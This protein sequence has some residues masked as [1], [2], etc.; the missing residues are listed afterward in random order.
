MAGDILTLPDLAN[1]LELLRDSHCQSLYEGELA[2][3]IIDWSVKTG[4]LL[5][6]GDLSEYRPQ[7][8][9]PIHTL[10]AAMMSGRSHQ[11]ARLSRPH[12]AQYCKGLYV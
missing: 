8:V 1:S 4:G 12:G 6:A 10:T 11:R 9:D 7:W 2:E 5:R 3:A